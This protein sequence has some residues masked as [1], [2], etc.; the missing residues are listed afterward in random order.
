MYRN[1]KQYSVWMDVISLAAEH[2][3]I[4]KSLNANLMKLPIN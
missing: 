2:S 4:S 3:V 1:G